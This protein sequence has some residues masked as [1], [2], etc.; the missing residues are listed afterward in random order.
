MI[1]IL[2]IIFLV[3]FASYYLYKK[4]NRYQ[5]LIFPLIY[6]AITLVFFGFYVTNMNGMQG[7]S[8][9]IFGSM[10]LIFFTFYGIGMAIRDLI[11]QS[12]TPPY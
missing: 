1:L 3:V 8:Y 10:P 6:L 7:L 11:R 9:F 4:T 12:L 5:F 2:M